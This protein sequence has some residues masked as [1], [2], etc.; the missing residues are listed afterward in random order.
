[1]KYPIIK[2]VDSY[3]KNYNNKRKKTKKR[4]YNPNKVYIYGNHENRL[5]SYLHENPQIEGI[6]D[7]ND[8]LGCKDSGW[9]IVEYRDTYYIEDIGFTHIP[10]NGANQPIS[11]K[12]VCRRALELYG[13]NIVFGHTHRIGVDIASLK[14][15]NGY[16][17]RLAINVGKYFSYTPEYAKNS[18]GIGDWWTGVVM[19]YKDEYLNFSF[20]SYDS[21]KILYNN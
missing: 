16:K 17:Q 8:I 3:I 1:V 11:G 7:S 9:T 20:I 21:M 12:Y 13:T 14:G 15:K 19:L 4:Y 18:A 6:I 5:I 10:M 2:I